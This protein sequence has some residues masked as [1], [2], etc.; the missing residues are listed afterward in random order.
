MATRN[1]A[2]QRTQ[3][4]PEVTPG[5]KLAATRRLP[6][7]S[8]MPAPVGQTVS[9]RGQ[10]FKYPSSQV[11]GKEWTGLTYDGAASYG[12]LPYI[13]ASLLGA[14]TPSAVGTGG[15]LWTF[16][17]SMTL[18]DTA[19]TY[20]VEHGDPTT[21]ANFGYGLFDG[22]TFTL[23]RDSFKINGTGIGQLWNSGF[24]MSV[25][26]AVQ[27]VTIT[28]TPTGGTFT[29]TFEGA[30][31]APIVYN[32]AP[33]AVQTALQA[34]PTVGP[35]VTVSG[36]ALPGGS[37]ICTFSGGLAGQ[38]VPAITANS[39]GLTGGVTPTAVVTQTTPGAPKIVENV[40]I[41]PYNCSIAVDPTFAN[42]GTTSLL[43]DFT[44]TLG[45]TGRWGPAWPI[46]G[47][48]S[49][50]GGIAEL[51]P[52]ASL[53]LEMQADTVSDGF[54]TQLR[55]SGVKYL[56]LKCTGPLISAGVYYGFTLNIPFQV[57]KPNPLKDLAGVYVADWDL[58]PVADATAGYA[59]NASVINMTSAL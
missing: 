10:G 33:A 57:E 24:T 54:I 59:I 38:P 13:L 25:T 20:T 4:I 19:Q 16:N 49:S 55:A 29:L 1:T 46:N 15:Y 41:L 37:A 18:P 5:T 28:G 26:N 22:C 42:I 44:L 12:E 31:T 23:T 45:L 9:F 56:Q 58:A 27:T 11:Y 8:I 40:P 32:A 3:I 53:K 52:K 39:A 30:T 34:L 21:G 43:N 17:H 51:V 35:N 48:L 2:T 7:L 50:F 14:A 36:T 47:A 6:N